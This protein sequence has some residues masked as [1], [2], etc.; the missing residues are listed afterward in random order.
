[1]QIWIYLLLYLKFEYRC[2]LYR[3]LELIDL[4]VIA[5]SAIHLS[6][7]TGYADKV[8]VIDLSVIVIEEIVIAPT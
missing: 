6:R 1:M 2:R 8:I 4:S 3:N 7:V 5:F